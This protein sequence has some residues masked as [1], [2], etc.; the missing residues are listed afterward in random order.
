MKCTICGDKLD[1]ESPFNIKAENPETKREGWMHGF[2]LDIIEPL[3][4]K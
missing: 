1:P 4:E 3:E 2:C